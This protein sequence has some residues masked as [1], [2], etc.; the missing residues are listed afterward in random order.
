MSD[1]PARAGDVSKRVFDIAWGIPIFFVALPLIVG[2][3]VGIV[4]G[5]GF[6]VFFWQERTGRDGRAFRLLKLR[7]MRV[8]ARSV[9][10]LGQ[11]KGD[12]DLVTPV[13][14]FLRRFKID[15]LPQI[16]NVFRGDM[17]LVGPRPAS[18]EI[19]ADYGPFERRRLEV[20]P[21]MTGWAQ[22]NGNTRLS[23]G[24]RHALD[25]WYVDHQSRWLDF[26]IMMGTWG[27]VFGGEHARQRRLKEALVYADRA[28][29]SG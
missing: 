3:I 25:V 23:W 5:M 7:T 21:G 19:T 11:V 28:A 15:E 1:G 12:H 29:R 26:C 8:N 4:V 16:W 22:I 9:K 27:V 17:S 2:G 13:G 6:P 20:K 24:E 14:R 10:D 18:V